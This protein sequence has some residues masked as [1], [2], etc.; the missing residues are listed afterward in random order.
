LLNTNPSVDSFRVS[1]S[2]AFLEKS[3]SGS[4][5][6]V[7]GFDRNLLSGT[8]SPDQNPSA[9]G[10]S[11]YSTLPILSVLVDLRLLEEQLVAISGGYRKPSGKHITEASR[12]RSVLANAGTTGFAKLLA[13]STEG[14]QLI[15]VSSSFDPVSSARNVPIGFAIRV[16]HP[17]DPSGDESIAILPWTEL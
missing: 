7:A 3:T 13:E 5:T 4:S 9:K 12:L 15:R 17:L 16:Q 6:W 14:V 11:I 2:P 10:L 8:A 1:I